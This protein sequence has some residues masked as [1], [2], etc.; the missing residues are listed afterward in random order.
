MGE[1][2]WSTCSADQDCASG[3]VCDATWHVCAPAGLLAVKPPVCSA[4]H[5]KKE[6]FGPALQIS[7]RSGQLGDYHLEPSGAIQRDGSFSAAFIANTTF[8]PNTLGVATVGLE[9]DLR[10]E[11]PLPGDRENAFDPWMARDRRGE[12]Y[13]VWLAFDGGRA[14]EKRMEIAL[15]HSSDG[16]TWSPPI[17]AHDPADCT[18]DHG[19]P[20][21]GCIDKPMIA[22][23]PDATDPTHEAIYVFY[24]ADRSD[25]LRVTH[26]R[27]GVHF[28]SPSVRVG[29]AAYANARVGR[30]GTV[31]VVWTEGRA[32]GKMGDP[33]WSVRYAES[34]D[35]GAS[36]TR[37]ATVSAPGQP[38][39]FFFSNA[40]VD[41]DDARKLLYV[42]YPAGTPDG[43]WDIFLATSKDRGASWSRT[44]INDDAPCA[45]HMTPNLAV[46]RQTGRVHLIW[47]ENRSGAGAVAY[48]WCE[49]GGTSCSPN[50]AVS[51]LPFAAYGF[52]RHSPKWL[53]EYGTLLIDR[54][55]RWLHAAWTQPV[56]EGGIPIARIFWARAKL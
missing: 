28:S 48:A 42:A 22:I 24:Y 14:P 54:D 40:A 12:M 13:T 27:D 31:R 35:G 53:G 41:V 7:G 46:D 55:R 50:E 52:A 17:A 16:K 15:S 43:R 33:G 10:S 32:A 9:G 47:I 20:V 49:A 21:D 3:A 56:L 45:N 8:A 23:G 1:F 38:I 18:D 44:R 2:C 37:A 25:S 26:S 19:Q 36:F 30:D 29:S 11:V 34:R 51:D 5:L 39:P 6:R 4:P